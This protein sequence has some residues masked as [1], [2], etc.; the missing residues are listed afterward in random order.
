MG[1]GNNSVEVIAQQITLVRPTSLDLSKNSF[2]EQGLRTLADA[3]SKLDSLIHLSLSG[4]AISSDSALYFFNAVQ[5][6]TH[7]TSLEL[8]NSENFISKIKIGTKGA[9]AL[10]SVMINSVLSILDLTDAGLTQEGH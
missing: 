7:L 9:Y 5:F 3:V 2:T 8:R 1:L 10:K 4:N 6:S